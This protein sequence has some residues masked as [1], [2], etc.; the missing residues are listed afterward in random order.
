MVTLT[1][2]TLPVSDVL[3]AYVGVDALSQRPLKPQSAIRVARL[4]V[5]LDRERRTYELARSAKVEALGE[6]DPQKPGGWTI[7]AED[8]EAQAAYW[9]WIGECQE[10]EITLDVELLSEDDLVEL[11]PKYVAAMLLFLDSGAEPEGKP[12]KRRKVSR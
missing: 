4:L 10:T 2:L 5:V 6:R 11:E 12:K 9:T 7:K 8:E 3:N 1:K